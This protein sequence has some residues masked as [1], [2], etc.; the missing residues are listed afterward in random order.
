MSPAPAFRNVVLPPASATFAR[1]TPHWCLRGWT[2]VSRVAVNWTTAEE[3]ELTA[4]GFYVAEACDGRTDLG[5]LAFLPEHRAALDVL[6][7]EGI[8]EVCQ[9]GDAIAPW[10]RYRA[11]PNPHL[12]T[13]HWCVTG[14]GN[15]NCRH[16]YMQSPS[17]RYGELAF[18]DVIRL[19]DQ[20]EAANV[21]RVSL[22]GG[23]PFLRRDLLEIM[24]LLAERRIGISEIYTNGL[25][26]TPTILERIRELGF[27]PGFQ[28]SFD[29]CGSHDDMR[30][31]RGLEDRVIQA[32]RRV[33]QH[34][35]AVIVAGSVDRAAVA[36]LRRTYDLLRSLD[37]QAWRLGAPIE[38]G[39]WRGTAS[40]LTLDEQADAFAPLVAWW[41]E[42]GRPFEIALGQFVRLPGRDAPPAEPEPEVRCT[43]ESYDCGSCRESPNLLPDGTLLPCPRYV[44]SPMQSR[45]PNILVEDLSKAWTASLLRDLANMRK[46][47][48]LACNED[49]RRCRF[50]GSCGSGCRASAVDET[51]NLMARD[52]IACRLWRGGYKERFRRLARAPGPAR[53]APAV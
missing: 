44:D 51:G 47:E 23:E 11:A 26:I 25:L 4:K 37:I 41:L 33:R 9:D 30:G 22:T 20:F 13:I 6:I 39:N 32:I 29:G 52:P 48:L 34:G 5:S 42:D 10:Q 21:L 35:C 1:L 7:A 3:F 12:T 53:A 19:V 24:G 18:E 36:G 38:A 16:C 49:C 8:A 14:R 28:I 45:M 17:G 31:R 50:F 43:P 27:S 15:L 46:H 2:D 40:G